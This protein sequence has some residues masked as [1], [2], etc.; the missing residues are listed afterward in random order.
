VYNLH[1]HGKNDAV[2]VHNMKAHGEVEVHRHSSL[3]PSL[4]GVICQLRASAALPQSLCYPLNT[5]FTPILRY[6]LVLRKIFHDKLQPVTGAYN[7][8]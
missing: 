3:D 6:K 2:P 1:L 4:D 7:V 8:C 5:E